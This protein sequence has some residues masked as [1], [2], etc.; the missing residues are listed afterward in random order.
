MI[1]VVGAMDLSDVSIV[2]NLYGQ[3]NQYHYYGMNIYCDE[4][5]RSTP[6]IVKFTLQFPLQ[7]L[8]IVLNK[9]NDIEILIADFCLREFVKHIKKINLLREHQTG[10]EKYTGAIYIYEPNDLV[11][12]RNTSYIKDD[13]LNIMLRIRFPVHMMEKRNVIAGKLSVKLIRKSLAR[14]I[15]DFIDEFSMDAYHEALTVFIRQQEIRNIIKK[16]GLVSFIAN[17]SILPKNHDGTTLQNAIPF[18]APKEDEVEFHLSDGFSIKG[19]GIKNGVTV[20]TGGGYS[21]KSTLLD[22]IM[23]GIYNHV[24]GDGREYCITQSNSC[25]IVAEDGRRITAMNIAPFIRN[26]HGKFTDDFSTDHASGS[27]SQAANIIESISFGC[28]LLLIDEDRTATNFMIRD[29][30]MKTIIKYDPIIPFTDRVR[31]IY[32]NTG[33]STILVIGG[34]SE[35]LDLADNVY[36]MKDYNLVNYNVE[37]NNTRQHN[38]EF[39]KVEDETSIA[40]IHKRIVDKESLNSFRKNPETGRIQEHLSVELN[41]IQVGQMVANIAQ[42]STVFTFPQQVA[43]AFCIRAICNNNDMQ[44]DDLLEIANKVYNDVVKEGL[45]K[46]YTNSFLIDP[47]MEL[48][49]FADIMFTLSRM[50][51][52]TY[53][54]RRNEN[55]S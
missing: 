30:R 32:E 18:I 53:K 38:Y 52:I 46:I 48:P 54:K 13:F 23:T 35:Y 7:Q 29:A 36:L 34:S 15:R 4:T 2:R 22:S 49:T 6:E 14:A 3:N 24:I 25:K 37:I 33:T 10:K 16:E 47:D 31:D 20:I 39:F 5:H 41:H 8:G 27:T 12:L 28:K 51:D 26:I 42:L 11:L 44:S 55:E 40:W 43:I 45:N 19:F 50:N 1:S 9:D 21:G 17:G